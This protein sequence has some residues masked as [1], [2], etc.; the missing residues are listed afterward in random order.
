MEYIIHN[1][2]Q[3]SLFACTE[4][5]FKQLNIEL[6]S[7]ED[8]PI[9]PQDF[10]DKELYRPENKV[11]QLI[12]QLYVAGMIGT[13]EDCLAVI[14]VELATT[15]TT[16]T[17]L[18]TITR[19]IN[20]Q[21]EGMPVAVLFR[22]GNHIAL[23]NAERTQYKQ[24]NREE[25]KIGKV[26]IL[27]DID[28]LNPHR[29]HLDILE[30]L[31]IPAKI[32]TFR[33]L[34][35]H[36][37]EVFN[38]STLNKKFYNELFAWFQWTISEEVGV[39]YPNDTKTDQDDRVQLEEQV[40]RLITRVLF[41][42]FIKQKHLV[43]NNLFEEAELGKILKD[44]QANS[45][46]KG[47][48]YNAILQNLFFATLNKKV[49]ERAFA[50]VQG[51]RDIKTLYRYADMFTITE[52]EV[53]A[54]FASIPFLNGG[55][56]E[57][58][59]KD[60]GNDGV[61]Y[62]L[63]GFSR[64][65][66]KSDHNG[67]YTHRAFIPNAVFFDSQKGL[68]PLLNRYHFTIEENTP[69]EVQVALD[70]ELLGNVFENL[71]GAFNP[72]T[73][74]SARKQSG[75][76]Y[77]P[78][79]VV[80]YMVDE[81]LKTYLHNQLPTFSSESLNMLFEETELPIEW[82]SQ[83]ANCQRVV[84]TLER[85]K[86]LDPACGSG[87]F[88][89]GILNRMVYLLEKLD[90][91]EKR[92]LYELKLHLIQ[93]C[94]YG[95]DIQ[96]IASQISKLRFFISLIVEQ[97]ETNTDAEQNYG[98]HTLPNL[99][100]KFVTANTL[101]SLEKEDNIELFNDERLVTLKEKLFKVR[102]EHF[103]AQSAFKKKELRKEDAE[104]CEN[105]KQ[106]LLDIAIKPNE[107]HIAFWKKSIE[108]L[109][110]EREKYVAERWEEVPMQVD[111]FAEAK[112]IK[113]DVNLAKRKEVD[114]KIK[115]LQTLIDKEYHKK[116]SD[117]LKK[118]LETLASW[119]PYDQN[120]SAPFFDPEWMFGISDG[121]DIVIG[122]PP[123]VSTKGVTS[124]FKKAL[125]KEYGFADD[126]YNHF[127]FR[128]YQILR[129]KGILSF[130]T[131]KTFWTTQTKR[132]L[133]DLL[134]SQRLEYIFDTA[135]PFESAMVDTCITSF[136][137]VKPE[138]NA[139][140]FLDGS[141]DLEKPLRYEVAQNV[142]IDTQNS[143]IFKPTEYN[144]KIHNLYGKKVK[145]LYEQW[146]DKI[147]TS[148]NITKYSKE[149]EAYRQSL[150][151]GDI[152]LLGCLTEGGQGLAT[153]NNGKYIAVRKSTKWAKNILESRPKKLLEVVKR[154][155]TAVKV[156][157]EEEAKDYLA[158]LSE[159]QIA[160]LFDEL[161]E[162]FGRDIF[163]QGYIYRL[164]E[165]D[166]MADVE[167]LTQDEKDNGIEPTKK[168]YVPY[169]KGDKDGNRWYLETPFAIAWNKE[170][171]GF[172]KSN[173]GKKGEG[174]PVV[175]NPQYYFKEGFCWTDV[176]STYL[177]SRLKKNG[178]F[179]VL[180]MSLFTLVPSLPDWYYVCLINSRLISLYVDNFINNT[181]HF[182]INDARQLPIII[183]DKD[184]LDKF[185]ELFKQAIQIKKGYLNEVELDNIQQEIDILVNELYT[186]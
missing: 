43:P 163:G 84:E 179:D 167:A 63:D 62:H 80:N 78:K 106:Y 16:R 110:T 115:E 83:P 61:R 149:L 71:L 13:E 155:K 46:E 9:L 57:C 116:E 141:K 185:E 37:Q 176:N 66:R 120:A 124:E 144:M 3:G 166:E 182:Q 53:I 41:V 86:I 2:A 68:F 77:T 121:F 168:F 75:S 26:S 143:V 60:K 33:D 27:K 93:N 10:F 8:L 113:V 44:F 48:Y 117:T 140:L 177:K 74:E 38:V 162:K 118:E 148:K 101:I 17:Q 170:N 15:A 18:S 147:S 137:K 134:L 97:E 186:I 89:M 153:A 82:L 146:W 172:L 174:M 136:S 145:E 154:Y 30:T 14:A 54:L 22:Y 114:S 119:N 96:T 23:A 42:W 127:F 158:A 81:S 184:T 34:Y 39:T 142:F 128:G 40:I 169:D 69:N 129:D 108:H 111:M 85:V 107:Q 131:P 150:K 36:W 90:F 25:E 73:K 130:I 59:D 19:L 133:R 50:K 175:R 70:P 100:T 164:I 165:D 92:S 159:E 32:N 178:V 64:N 105:I 180:S 139:L 156:A 112:P 49:T 55:L 6:H 56:F 21:A 160:T 29:G 65:D 11:H 67:H 161:K 4:Q 31:K 171:V 157:N 28:I 94:I 173:S 138:N 51:S 103:Y 91:L 7:S 1:F 95:V 135:N 122:N 45:L 35:A 47:N 87:A 151:P 152:A 126:T 104:I 72:E 109:Q 98:V 125:E 24:T 181:S 58:L 102:T 88:P 132:N 12:Q 76:F 99:E 52:E 123:Y 183:P 20:R 5:L 79:E